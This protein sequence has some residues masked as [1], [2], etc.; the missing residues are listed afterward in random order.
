MYLALHFG[1]FSEV[2]CFKCTP[3]ASLHDPGM[4]CGI[5]MIYKKRKALR[6]V[7]F[8]LS[9]EI[10]VVWLVILLKGTP[11]LGSLIY[12]PMQAVSTQGAHFTLCYWWLICLIYAVFIHYL[13]W[14]Y[15]YIMFVL[16]LICS[17]MLSWCHIVWQ[18]S[19]GCIYGKMV[20]K[21]CIYGLFRLV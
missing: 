10:A 7:P 15:I 1:A 4:W 20:L 9:L 3:I 19:M 16:S 13:S 18:G 14:G 5:L 12:N 11:P 21:L 17:C 8:T 6:K 2:L